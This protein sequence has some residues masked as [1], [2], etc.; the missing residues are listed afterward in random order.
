MGGCAAAAAP[1]YSN[2]MEEVLYGLNLQ[3]SLTP[4]S[5]PNYVSLP[6]R[7]NAHLD[8]LVQDGFIGHVTAGAV[9]SLQ[10]IWSEVMHQRVDIQRITA[11][12]TAVD[13]LTPL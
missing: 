13:T 11:L 2:R 6:L 5:R 10:E 1:C 9:V 7:S 8:E 12:L 4:P 3:S